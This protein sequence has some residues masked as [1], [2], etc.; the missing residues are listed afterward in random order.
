ME[1]QFMSLEQFL[2]ILRKRIRLILLTILV[3]T[4][5][6][7]VLS[8]YVINP[9]YEATT[10]FFIGKEFSEEEKY[11]NQSDVIMYQNLIKTYSEIIKTPD[12]ILNSIEKS[13]ISSE[14]K[15]VTN[16]LEVVAIADTQILE[17]RYR[18]IDPTES[19]KLVNNLTNEFIK[20]SRELVPNG[21]VKIIQ[22]V[23]VSNEPV[24]PNKPINILIGV[25]SGIVVGLL[26]AFIAE[27]LDKKIR[28]K[29]E[30]ENIIDIP[31]IGILPLIEK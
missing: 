12:I 2:G 16:R 25:F 26:I 14:V 24:T 17:V 19:R 15:D 13:K 9:K 18:S 5:I 29:E 21:S 28:S 30:L 11:Y 27:S 8:F 23:R 7:I 4:V 3:F 10:K 31:I 6:S 20:I 22:K 1:D